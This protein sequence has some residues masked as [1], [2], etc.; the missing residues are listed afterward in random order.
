MGSGLTA[1]EAERKFSPYVDAETMAMVNSLDEGDRVYFWTYLAET[2]PP[3]LAKSALMEMERSI[4]NAIRDGVISRPDEQEARP[5]KWAEDRMRPG[6]W[7]RQSC[8]Q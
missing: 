8:I 6:S 1:A 3:R 7:F 2:I 5:F 4:A